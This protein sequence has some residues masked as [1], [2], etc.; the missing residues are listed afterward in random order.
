MVK[1]LYYMMGLVVSLLATSCSESLEETYDEYAGNGMI[2]YLGK[3]ADVEVNPGWNR[4]QVVWKHSIDAGVKKVKITWTSDKGSGEMFVPPC[5]PDSEDLMDTVYIENLSDAMYTVRVNNVA[6]NGQESLVEEKYGRPYSFEH[7]DLRSF[8]RGVTAFSRMGD[9]LAV[10]LDQDNENIKEMLLCF[11]GKDGNKHNWNMKEHATDSL[12]Y[13][14]YG[15][16]T[17]ELG[18]DYLFLLPDEDGVE[19]D[20]N[21]PITVRRS[22]KLLGCVDEINFEDVVLNLNERLWSTEFTQLMLGKYGPGWESLADEVETLELDYDVP[23]MQDLMYFPKLKKV[24]L[25]KNRYMNSKYVKTS[26]SS[27]DEYMGLVM[28]QFLKDTRPDFTV[29]RYNEHYFYERDKYGNLSIEAYKEAGKLT[30]LEIVEKDSCNLQAK[31]R[32]V[33][34]DTT[35]WEMTCSDTVYNGYKDNGVANL[36]FDGMQ[37]VVIDYGWG[38]IYEYDTELYFEPAE[39]VGAAVVSVTYDMKKPQIVSGFKVGQPYRDQ[40]GD[41]EYLLSN[42]KVEFSVDGLTWTNA[43]HTDGNVTFGNSP[44]EE[45]YILVPEEMRNPVRY[46]RLSM[47]NRPIGTISS[48]TKYCLRLGTFIPCSVE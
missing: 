21:Q 8:S 18:R 29:E 27:T 4:L 32:F 46:I 13:L 43:N 7:E 9:K 2:R 17:V 37:H 20:F 39:T 12:V 19:I 44:A 24:V 41:T 42:L 38:Y 1:K 6:G 26:R 23:S 45:A 3:C 47:T 48:M 10:V 33:A 31:P 22:G 40:K 14:A 5:D 16:Y 11:T 36:L 30:D 28:L 34:L 15:Y 35:G 25:G